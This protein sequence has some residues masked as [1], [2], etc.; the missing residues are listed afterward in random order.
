MPSRL[1]TL[2]AFLLASIP[3]HA[4]DLHF[5]QFYHQPL[6]SNPAATGIFEG[7]W[8]VAGIYRS[9]WSSVPV[10]YQTFGAAFD[11]KVIRRGTSLMSGGLLLARDQAGDAG[12]SWTQVG[13]TGSVARALSDDQAVVVGVGLN[14]V[15]RAFDIGKL[16]FKNQWTGDVYDPALSTGESLGA[17]SG[18]APALSAGL[19]WHYG[20]A[21]T[22]TYLDAGLGMAY[23]NRPV[24]SFQ[25]DDQARLP[26]RFSLLLQGA[27]QLSDLLDVVGFASVQQLTT[28]R[29]IIAGAGLRRTLVSGPVNPT[30]V[31]FSLAFRLADALT[32]A[33]QLER[34]GW[35]VGLSYDW[36]ISG[37]RTATRQRGGFEIAAV[38]RHLSVPPVKVFK[39]CPIF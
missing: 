19:L 23:L 27:R 24:L 17:S 32:P 18:F 31:Q 29:E 21:D 2:T 25:D 33:V 20:P 38:Y 11:T 10:N 30:A 28:A 4:Q 8:R 7:D 1:L 3:V 15:Q 36:N 26:M 6:P 14:F 5:S 22:R 34:N 35:T 16:K 13:L 9:Q 12:L 37:F 39:S